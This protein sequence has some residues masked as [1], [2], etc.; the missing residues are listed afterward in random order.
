MHVE[1]IVPGLLAAP[2]D[3]RLP[4]LEL[5]LARGRSSAGDAQGYFSWLGAAFGIEPLPAG[6]LSASAGGFWLRA[7][8]V[9]LHLLR[10]RMVLLPVSGLRPDEA[11]QLVAA[12]NRHFAGTHEFRCPLPDCWVVRMA[13]A[14]IDTLGTLPTREVAGKDFDAH[15]PGAPWP[16]LLNEIQMV[17]HEHPVNEAREQPVNSVWL[18]GP[19][20]LPLAASSR[21][22]SLTANEPVAL[23][24]ARVAGIGHRVPPRTGSSWLAS[25]TP[26]DGQHL[27][28][29]DSAAAALEADWFAPLLEALRSGRVGMLTIQVPDAGLSFETTRPDLRRFWRRPRALASHA[30]R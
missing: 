10:D 22:R 13:P 24:L 19:G 3:T 8:P 2:E 1:L 26:Q 21:W 27:V 18:W 15:L 17:L 5:L 11:D 12:L 30:P 6:A 29:L 9:H 25:A 4:A 16:A 14:A 28:V 7:D 20:E 23:G